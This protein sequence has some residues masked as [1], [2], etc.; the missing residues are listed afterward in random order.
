MRGNKEFTKQAN[1]PG[2]SVLLPIQCLYFSESP[3]FKG[4]KASGK[5]K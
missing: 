4:D 5:S 1:V 3:Q 2:I